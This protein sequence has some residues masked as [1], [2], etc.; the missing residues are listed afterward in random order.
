MKDD[1]AGTLPLLGAAPE[2]AMQQAHVVETK[3]PKAAEHQAGGGDQ[4]L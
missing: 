4:G 2:A 3:K 1:G